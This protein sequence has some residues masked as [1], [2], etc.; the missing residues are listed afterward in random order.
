MWQIAQRDC[1]AVMGFDALGVV[2]YTTG[3]TPSVMVGLV[4]II[5]RRIYRRIETC[6]L[7]M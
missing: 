5:F 4:A 6:D 7:Y 2:A 3:T 1:Y